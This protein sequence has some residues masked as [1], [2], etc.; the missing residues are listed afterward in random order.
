MAGLLQTASGIAINSSGVVIGS[1]SSDAGLGVFATAPGIYTD[2]S[3]DE[4]PSVEA[5]NDSNVISTRWDN[6]HGSVAVQQP[7]K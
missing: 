2:F 5:L 7:M 3:S 1:L 4:L 6:A